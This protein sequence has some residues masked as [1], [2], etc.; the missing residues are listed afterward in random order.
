MAITSQTEK[1]FRIGK[2][3]IRNWG[4]AGLLKPSS[5]KPAIG[6]LYGLNLMAIFEYGRCP[7]FS[8]S[9][10]YEIRSQELSMVS[11]ELE[12]AAF[13]T[14]LVYIHA[15]HVYFGQGWGEP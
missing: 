13:I 8:Y 3:L 14:L 9:K 1:T 2:C 4:K 15:L 12:L 11:P 5:I 7:Y 10:N 6:G